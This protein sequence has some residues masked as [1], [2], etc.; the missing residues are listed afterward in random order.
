MLSPMRATLT[1]V[2]SYGDVIPFVAIAEALRE[3]DHHVRVCSWRPF[4]RLFTER[5]IGFTPVGG[6]LD[7]HG[8][9]REV[10][11]AAMSSPNPELML[12]SAF[13][14]FIAFE[15]R[16]RF[17]DCRA[18]ML[19]ADVAVCN[20][21]D[22][23]AQAA[24]ESLGVPWFVWTS[25][26]LDRETLP[27]SDAHFADWDRRANLLIER[28]TGVRLRARAFRNMSPNE[29]YF[30]VS[31]AL[32]PGFDPPARCFVTGTCFVDEFLPEIPIPV[33]EFLDAGGPP[34]VVTFGAFGELLPTEAFEAILKAVRRSGVRAIVHSKPRAPFAR[35]SETLLFV[36]SL[37]YA[38]VF[39]RARAVLHHGGAGTTAE[40]CRAGVPSATLCYID[41]DQAYWA[42]Q[43]H[44]LGIAAEPLMLRELTVDALRERLTDALGNDDMRR[45][46]LALA[47]RFQHENGAHSIVSRL[48]A[49]ERSRRANGAE[50]A[51]ESSAE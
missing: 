3:R 20:A 4:E 25:K 9:S 23:P 40:V 29:T 49:F 15:A 45:R 17:D 22:L 47:P 32:L 35:S 6:E 33:R 43:I 51:S 26:P 27:L 36:E 31:P 37:P 18:A 21:L 34:L 7:L 11:G 38:A 19:G 46:A 1:T 16:R 42:A 30:G 50:V 2:G 10:I 48:E 24:A 14:L 12:E 8:Y 39:P 44:G 41:S 28:E 13:E 5:N